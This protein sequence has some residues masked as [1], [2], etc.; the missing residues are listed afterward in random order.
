MNTGNYGR[1]PSWG[2]RLP[3]KAIARRHPAF[4]CTPVFVLDYAAAGRAGEGHEEHPLG[5]PPRQGPKVPGTLSNS[6]VPGTLPSCLPTLHH[7]SLP[8]GRDGG[9]AGLPD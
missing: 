6:R 5:A 9:G 2:R 1:R 3:A 7:S 8:K 4:D